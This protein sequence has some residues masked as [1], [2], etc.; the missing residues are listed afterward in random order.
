ML[1]LPLNAAYRRSPE[2]RRCRSETPHPQYRRRK[3]EYGSDELGPMN[4]SIEDGSNGLT[5]LGDPAFQHIAPYPAA[6]SLR[7]IIRLSVARNQYDFY[8]GR[9][10][11][12]FAQ[13]PRSRPLPAW[14]CR[15]TRYP[16][17]VSPQ[18]P[19][20]S[21][22]C[23]TFATTLKLPLQLPPQGLPIRNSSSAISTEG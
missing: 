5:Q 13:L 17:G 2:K 10:A 7:D 23:L 8:L 4:V 1:P 18:S 6:K 3:G 15:A 21:R 19:A 16:D 22:P 20:A 12:T 11:S 9:Q 14:R